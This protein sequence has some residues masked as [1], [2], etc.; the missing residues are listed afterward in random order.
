[1]GLWAVCGADLWGALQVVQGPN[2]FL[3]DVS[4][5][6]RAAQSYR[7]T[8]DHGF[9]VFQPPLLILGPEKEL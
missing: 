1:L 4:A 9:S 3:S 6:A 8:V 5:G 7:T 2:S